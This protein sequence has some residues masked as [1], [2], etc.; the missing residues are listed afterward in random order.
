LTAIGLGIIYLGLFWQK[1][2]KKITQKLRGF[3]PGSLRELLE[4]RSI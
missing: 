2:E 4:E 1:H 3:L